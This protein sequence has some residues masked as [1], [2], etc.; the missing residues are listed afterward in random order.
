MTTVE[1]QNAEGTA[2]NKGDALTEEIKVVVKGAN[3]AVTTGED[4]VTVDVKPAADIAKVKGAF[5]VDKNFFKTYTGEPITLD[6]DDFVSGKI[7]VGT[8]ELGKDFNIVAYKNN[9]KKGTMTVTVQGDGEYSG[10]K[11]FKVKI[12]AKPLDKVAPEN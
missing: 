12:K 7:N 11:T 9:I 6:A 4:G 1:I 2:L 10:T 8:L 5:K 3:A